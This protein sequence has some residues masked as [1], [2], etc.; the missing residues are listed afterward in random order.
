MPHTRSPRSKLLLIE[1]SNEELYRRTKTTDKLLEKICNKS[2][3]RVHSPSQGL[4]WDENIP[5]KKKGRPKKTQRRSREQEVVNSCT[6][7]Q[8]QRRTQDRPPLKYLLV[9]LCADQQGEGKIS[10]GTLNNLASFSVK[11]INTYKR[12]ITLVEMS[13]GVSTPLL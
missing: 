13:E 6:G 3:E 9:A 5:A 8:V 11:K 10:E 12:V 1:I 4:R 2:I 7:R